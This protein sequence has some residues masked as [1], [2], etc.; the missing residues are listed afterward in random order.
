MTNMPQPAEHSQFTGMVVGTHAANWGQ[1]V[2]CSQFTLTV[3]GTLYLVQKGAPHGKHGRMH[4]IHLNG[5]ENSRAFTN[6][7]DS[8]YCHYWQ[9]CI[10]KYL[11]FHSI[12][13]PCIVSKC[14][15]RCQWVPEDYI[16]MLYTSLVLL[17]SNCMSK[18]KLAILAFLYCGE[19]VKNSSILKGKKVPHVTQATTES[20]LCNSYTTWYSVFLTLLISNY[21][22]NYH[23]AI[24][25]RT[26][27]MLIHLKLVVFF[28][29]KK[30]SCALLYLVLIYIYEVF[31]K[32]YQ[33]IN[34]SS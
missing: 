5:G 2:E 25:I 27:L 9:L 3:V 17:I 34:T 32:N 20:P 24:I 15:I 1:M 21:M 30:C 19:F 12:F 22:V 4:P 29:R 7:Q 18:T 31:T 8:Q 10:P 6:I 33:I 14:E 11:H 26:G 16:S 28:I 13:T 23:N